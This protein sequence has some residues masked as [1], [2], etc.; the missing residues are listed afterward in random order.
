M[1]DESTEIDI[2]E[3]EA[4]AF[5]VF[6]GAHPREAYADQ[7]ERFWALFHCKHPRVPRETMELALRE[8]EG[9]Q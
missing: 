3:A 1:S 2:D 5:E 4:W 8:T 9:N 6:A 7:P